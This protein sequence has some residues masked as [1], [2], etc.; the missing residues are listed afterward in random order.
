MPPASVPG[1]KGWHREGKTQC[2][3][4]AQ[5]DVAQAAKCT[6]QSPRRTVLQVWTVEGGVLWMSDSRILLYLKDSHNDRILMSTLID[7]V[8]EVGS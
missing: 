7:F 5:G 2:G 1:S 8:S 6:S 3:E 4:T